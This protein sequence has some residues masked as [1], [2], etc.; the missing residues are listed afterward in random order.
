MQVIFNQ[1]MKCCDEMRNFMWTNTYIF[2]VAMQNVMGKGE[3][4]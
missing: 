3:G 2:A 4:F 1:G